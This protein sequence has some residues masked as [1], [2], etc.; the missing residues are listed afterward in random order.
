LSPADHAFVPAP[1]RYIPL[2]FKALGLAGLLLVQL[3]VFSAVRA[4]GEAGLVVQHG[5]GSTE[6]Y[7]IAFEGS[8]IAGDALLRRAGVPVEQF[9]G[10]VCS[11]GAR[12][13]EGCPNA[14]S[15][16]SCTCQ[17]SGASCVYWAFFTRAHG[18]PWVY[19]AIGFTLHAARD[20]D[21]HGWKWGRGGPSSAAA[22]GD[23]TF[24]QVCGHPPGAAAVPT[25]APPTATPPPAAAAPPATPPSPPPAAVDQSPTEAPAVSAPAASEGTPG[26]T[27]QAESP[28]E[29]PAVSAQPSPV[30]EPSPAAGV[31]S[32]S[33]PPADA[34]DPQPV[35]IP[36]AAAEN[37]TSAAT[38]VVTF[39]AVT[40]VLVAAIG[41]AALLRNR[42]GR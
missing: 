28:A 23:I 31:E 1:P 24:E 33:T 7:C 4:D 35:E 17:C 38:G 29:T 32:S 13:G 9:S 5:D 15:F 41:A 20:G 6:T 37:G 14:S 26:E 10:L 19:S 21:L 40:S 16:D 18:K 22:P 42:R 8:S 36:V 11:L 30:E 27:P 39:V 3:V 12:P 2:W 34:G 25:Q